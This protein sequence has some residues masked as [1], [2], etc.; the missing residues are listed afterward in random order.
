MTEEQLTLLF[1]AIT[2]VIAFIQKM[3]LGK[4]ILKNNKANQTEISKKDT[5]WQE[6]FNDLEKRIDKLSNEN[7]YYRSEL[8]MNYKERLEITKDEQEKK[9]IV[10]KLDTLSSF[11]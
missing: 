10:A 9:D 2:S 4:V 6:K 5:E 3:N 1:V 8:V 7:A 11:K